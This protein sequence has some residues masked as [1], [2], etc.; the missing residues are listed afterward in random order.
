MQTFFAEVEEVKEDIVHVRN[1]T[2]RIAQLNTE[3]SSA[4][5]TAAE[6]EISE[7][8]QEVINSTNSHAAHAKGLLQLIKEQTQKGKSDP[9]AKASEIKYVGKTV[10]GKRY[11]G[12]C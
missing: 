8:L 6:T 3:A 2:K 4:A 5:T 12:R 7:E 11:L 10:S 1:A 9:S